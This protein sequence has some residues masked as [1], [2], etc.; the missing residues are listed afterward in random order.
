VSSIGSV[1]A[2]A[3]LATTTAANTIATVH[4]ARAV[5]RAGFMA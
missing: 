2:R 4:G 3:P 1:A 5:V